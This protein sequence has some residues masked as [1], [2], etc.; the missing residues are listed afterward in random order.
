[1]DGTR[2]FKYVPVIGAENWRRLLRA[3]AQ[4]T[5]SS[6]LVAL[7]VGTGQSEDSFCTRVGCDVSDKHTPFV[8]TNVEKLFRAYY[9]HLHTDPFC[10]HN[11]LPYVQMVFLKRGSLGLTPNAVDVKELSIKLLDEPYQL[12]KDLADHKRLAWEC[13]KSLGKVNKVK[14]A[15]PAKDEWEDNVSARIVSFSVESG[16]FEVQTARYSDQVGTNLTL[17]W[18]SG[19]LK[20]KGAPLGTR[21][22]IRNSFERPLNGL[23]PSLKD[24]C[25]ANT[26]GVA[27]TF[28]AEDFVPITTVRSAKTAIFSNQVLHCTASGVFKTECFDR[29]TRSSDGLVPF[30][31]FEDGMRKE[32]ETEMGL[33]EHEYELIPLVFAREL[34]RGG[35]PQL[36]FAAHTSIGWDETARRLNDAPENWERVELKDCDAGLRERLTDPDFDWSKVSEVRQLFTPEGWTS[37]VL[38][39]TYARQRM[40]A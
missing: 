36:F 13:F 35:K 34:S 2:R 23:L 7:T 18:A 33:K 22:T 28:L 39:L 38:A 30:D 14:Q 32:I 21:A 20:L 4:D 24:S 1:M 5:K 19:G 9:G 6:P 10:Y 40:G 3:L 31:A 11:Y 37:V 25:L 8:E 12:P 29:Y 26:L 17:D 27:V 15:D 16:I